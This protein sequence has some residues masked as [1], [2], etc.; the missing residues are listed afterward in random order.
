V[1][2]RRPIAPRLR[3]IVMVVGALAASQIACEGYRVADTR[4]HVLNRIGYG[5]DTWSQARIEQI[6]VW[7]YIEEQL[8]PELLDDSALEAQIASL[9]PV[10]TLSYT[11][12]RATYGY[13]GEGMTGPNVPMRDATRAK[14]LR[15][16]LSKRQLEQV[17]VDFWYNHFNVD[18]GVEEA[19][20]GFLPFERDA[21]R[22]HVFG[23]FE[24]MLRAT[25]R[26]PAM[27]D[28]LDNAS[29]FVQGVGNG[30]GFG[31]NEN[32]AREI[33]ELH[34]MGVD[35]GYTQ[36]D[37]R[38]VARAFTGWSFDRFTAPPASAFVFYADGH[39]REPKTVLGL[40]LPAGRGEEDAEDVMH[41]LA[42]MPQT[43]ERISRKLCQRFLSETPP[44]NVVQGAADVFLATQGDL[45]EVYRSILHSPEFSSV[46]FE[47]TKLKRPLVYAASLARA[48]GIGDVATFAASV[49]GQLPRMGE[50]LYRAGPPTGYPDSSQYWSGEASQIIRMNLAWNATHG[51]NGFAPQLAVTG[52]TPAEIVDELALQLLRGRIEPSTRQAL[53]V[54]AVS[55][56]A[57]ERVAQ[58]AATL[59][60]SPDFQ[61]H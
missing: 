51:L 11:E 35:G 20:W 5:P 26:S 50:A 42:H 46:A 55:V 56:P 47:R 41:L 14:L 19:R 22:P 23:R 30:L 48:V 25:A 34:T 36:Q 1:E 3:G 29:N 60:A 32:Y 37:V 6:G 10:T 49:D 12:S 15:A 57:S 53:I 58:V 38:E 18:A 31:L 24:D 4:H 39:D 33:L 54:L 2:A 28:Y 59:L 13:T 17:L 43:A 61:L 9:Y 52:T 16:V 27:L 45:R 7:A 21:I 40:Q 8:R 44:E